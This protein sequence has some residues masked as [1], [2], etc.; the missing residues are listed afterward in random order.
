MSTRS[1]RHAAEDD[2]AAVEELHRRGWTDG[3]PV[4]VPTPQRV[5]EMLVMSGGLDP[6]VVLGTIGPA[7]GEATV[8]KV[9]VNAVMAGCTPAMLPVAMA[10]VEAVA[11][12]A[13]ELSAVQ[14]TTHGLGP[15]VL[16][17]GPV[18]RECGIAAGTGA[19]GPGHRANACIG[20]ALRL[21]LMNVGGGRT[22]TGDMAQL[23]HPGKFTYCVAE[24]EERSPFEPFH[25]SRGF[26]V[27]DSVV[28]VLGAEAP[29]SVLCVTDPD[30]PDPVDRLVR[31]LGA[32]LANT[33]S[34]NV[35][36]GKGNVAVILN[37]THAEILAEH[38]RHVVQERIHAHAWQHRS[39]LRRL[40]GD[41]IADGAGDD[42]LHV[43]ANPEDIL[44]FVAGGDGQY[45]V[46]LPTWA[47]GTHGSLA[48]SR[49]V[50]HEKACMVPLT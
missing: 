1:E 23:G 50:R 38:P 42:R 30:E 14:V 47:A 22:G 6:D 7:D 11:D 49:S 39:L 48:I 37:P 8:E 2:A 15:L 4:I 45:S 28:T 32:S 40:G 21:V 20:R 34:N 16:V 19:L 3:L 33:G 24:D 35:Y 41:L 25:V 44:L 17:N 29:H 10:A 26:D 43:T 31:L 13:F 36:L 9:A 46:V 5:D 27:E 12:P 18:R